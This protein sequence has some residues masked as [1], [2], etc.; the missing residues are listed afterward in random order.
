MGLLALAAALLLTGWRYMR[1]YQEARRQLDSGTGGDEAEALQ[2][3]LR[4]SKV[5]TKFQEMFVVATMVAAGI[6]GA[7]GL[8]RF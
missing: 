7:V 8:T 5:P 6:V 4:S 1:Q 3:L 2:A